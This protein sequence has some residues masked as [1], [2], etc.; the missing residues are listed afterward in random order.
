M[1]PNHNNG[2]IYVENNHTTIAVCNADHTCQDLYPGH[3]STEVSTNQSE[4]VTNLRVTIANVSRVIPRIEE[5][6]KVTTNRQ[7]LGCT[8]KVYSKIKNITCSKQI[9]TD[10]IRVTCRSMPL[11]PQ[12]RCFPYL[13]QMGFLTSNNDMSYS[14]EIQQGNPTFYRTTCT[15]SV[16]NS[17]LLKPGAY[18]VVMIM[19]PDVSGTEK[20]IELGTKSS[21][22]IHI[23]YPTVTIQTCPRIVIENTTV[24]CTCIGS[25]DSDINA[26][27]AWYDDD[28]NLV[29]NEARL[30]FTAS[31]NSSSLFCIATNQLG[32]KGP[33]LAYRP[34]IIEKFGPMTCKDHVTPDVVTV[35]CSSARAH[36]ATACLFS[37]NRKH[38]RIQLKNTTVYI[39]TIEKL[40]DSFCY[41][42]NCTLVAPATSLSPGRYEILATMYPDVTGHEKD[43]E[44]GINQTLSIHI[45]QDHIKCGDETAEDVVIVWCL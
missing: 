19:Y 3:Y 12:G 29:D 2:D 38:K 14:N 24:S 40:N 25:D 6:W 8:L 23:E 43:L 20:D 13:L 1:H 39:N 42:T 37:I 17:N 30:T 35:S 36:R 26:T 28:D 32:M 16:P 33:K 4:S 18:E 15:L 22:L 21:F 34:T 9:F 44:F 31:R 11:Y 5:M 45:N 7:V 10:S 41:S 27:V